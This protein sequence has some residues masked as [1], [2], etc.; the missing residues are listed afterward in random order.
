LD[1]G[2]LVFA[3]VPQGNHVLLSMMHIDSGQK[4]GRERHFAAKI[5]SYCFHFNPYPSSP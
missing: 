5:P 2:F 3:V 1:P 4:S